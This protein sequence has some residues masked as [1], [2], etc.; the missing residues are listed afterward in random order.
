MLLTG[1]FTTSY[2]VPFMGIHGNI[3]N[4]SPELL[5]FIST[6]FQM[7]RFCFPLDFGC[8][9][10]CHQGWRAQLSEVQGALCLECIVN[11]NLTLVFFFSTLYSVFPYFVINLCGMIFWKPPRYWKERTILFKMTVRFS[12]WMSLALQIFLPNLITYCLPSAIWYI[13][14]SY[15]ECDTNANVSLTQT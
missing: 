3:W 14:G 11:K 4:K 7:V 1:S 2:S 15:K 13:P 5:I 10:T 9:G 6:T 12:A 8:R